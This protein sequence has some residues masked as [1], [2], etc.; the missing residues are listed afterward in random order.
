[1]KAGAST[2]ILVPCGPTSET[3][4]ARQAST[5]FGALRDMHSSPPVV[6]APRTGTPCCAGRAFELKLIF[7][8]RSTKIRG[9]R[10]VSMNE[11][12]EVCW[13]DTAKPARYTEHDE[14][15]RMELEKAA[16]A[17]RNRFAGPPPVAASDETSP[18]ALPARGDEP[19]FS[20]KALS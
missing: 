7:A 13:L 20:S 15:N 2:S 14:R 19:R 12:Q 1:V 5:S 16:I 3:D 6:H 17:A 9:H 18:A 11:S 10:V 8:T 4:P